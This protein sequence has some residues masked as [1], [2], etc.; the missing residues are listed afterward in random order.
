MPGGVPGLQIQWEA[1]LTRLRWVRFPHASAN[2]CVTRLWRVVF[3]DLRK[4]F[5][6]HSPQR[7][8]IDADP[9][10]WWLGCYN[11]DVPPVLMSGDD[12]KVNANDR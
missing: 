9:L 4:T 2:V 5:F 6:L 3:Y 10:F 12:F 8:S 11:V 7:I 1:W